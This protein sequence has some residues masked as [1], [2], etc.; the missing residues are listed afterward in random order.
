MLFLAVVGSSPDPCASL[1]V[2]LVPNA[3]VADLV[4][5]WPYAALHLVQVS[6]RP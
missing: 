6:P 3:T 4:Q 2:G 1:P 5:R